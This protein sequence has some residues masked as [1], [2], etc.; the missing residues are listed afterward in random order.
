[1][2]VLLFN[3]SRL[4]TTWNSDIILVGESILIITIR[5]TLC[6]YCGATLS[7]LLLN[8]DNSTTSIHIPTTGL[9]TLLYQGL[10]PGVQTMA[11]AAGVS[12]KNKLVFKEMKTLQLNYLKHPQHDRRLLD[13][14]KMFPKK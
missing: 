8:I 13:S 6:C 2:C 7:S 9:A 10:T 14:R 11:R 4:T 1:M 12:E 3:P 5:H